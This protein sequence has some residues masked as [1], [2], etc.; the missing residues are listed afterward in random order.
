MAPQALKSS[1]S[2]AGISPLNQLEHTPEI[3]LMLSLHFVQSLPIIALIVFSASCFAK[4]PWCEVLD[5]A[6]DA[7][8]DEGDDARIAP[9]SQASEGCVGRLAWPM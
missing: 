4:W 9:G 2:H 6:S 5:V 8:C 7:C 3:S 1:Q